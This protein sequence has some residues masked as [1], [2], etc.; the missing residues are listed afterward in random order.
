MGSDNSDDD[1]RALI[2]LTGGAGIQ[3]GGGFP[4]HCS[5]F[6]IAFVVQKNAK[7]RKTTLLNAFLRILS[8]LPDTHPFPKMRSSPSR[9]SLLLPPHPHHP[10][11][12]HPSPRVLAAV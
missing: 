3:T 1:W 9:H 2:E 12:A 4:V 5:A 10:T 11:P 7:K 6:H 8:H